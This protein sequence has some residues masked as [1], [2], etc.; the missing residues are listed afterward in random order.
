MPAGAWCHFGQK[1]ARPDVQRTAKGAELG[2]EEAKY[3]FVACQRTPITH[4]GMRLMHDP[5][6]AK[7]YIDVVGCDKT[8]IHTHRIQKRDTQRY[9][10]MR[11]AHWGSFIDEAKDNT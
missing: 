11:R 10:Q 2:W 4:T 6:R 1:I 8:G 7:G 5:M 3:T 9:A